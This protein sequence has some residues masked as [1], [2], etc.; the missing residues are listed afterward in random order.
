MTLKKDK[1]YDPFIEA[2][3]QFERAA[4]FLDIEPWIYQRLKHPE[5]ELT[6]HIAITRDSGRVESFTGYRVQHSTV[7]GPAKG[8]IRY[9]PDASLSECKALAAWMTWKTAVCDLPFGGSKGAI[10]CDAL[11]MSENELEKL[12][13]EYTYA[14]KDIIGPYKDIPAPDMFTNSQTMAWI[15]DAYSRA[16]GH[17]EPS[18]VTGKPITL[19]GSQ[20]RAG[21]TGS[22]L[23]FVLDEAAKHLNFPLVNKKVAILGFGNVGTS[24][25]KLVHKA[26]CKIIAVTDIFGGIYNEN[27]IDPFDLHQ[28][29]LTTGSVKHFSDTESIDNDNLIALPIDILIPA[30][31]EGQIHSGN[32]ST[33]NARIV[34]E[35]A[36]GP[37]TMEADEILEHNGTL[38]VPDIL[39]N[40]GGV[41]V[42]YLEWVQ[43]LQ[44]YF[45]S[46]DEI[47]ERTSVK[48]KKSFWEII[49]IVN[50]HKVCMRAAAY[51]LAVNRVAESMRQ[52]GRIGRN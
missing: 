15:A 50:K 19:W 6:V 48:M 25:A 35:G 2:T 30:A 31:M 20:G 49:D 4:A 24:I 17:F 7:R 46:E 39:A 21:A 22:G 47:L 34:L 51:I 11:K 13:K 9:S 43:D 1:E 28:H 36:N 37:T 44:R 5:K 38:V 27:G 3:L 10:I 26:G 45:L 12:T 29:V 16:N 33:I 18:V 42:S 52:L 40:A 23:F 32:A 41:T 14:I 8:G